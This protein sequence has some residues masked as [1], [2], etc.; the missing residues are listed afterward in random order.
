MDIWRISDHVDHELKTIYHCAVVL[1]S[2]AVVEGKDIWGFGSDETSFGH[3]SGVLC[4][5]F[6]LIHLVDAACC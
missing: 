1:G 4:S 3:R 2:E 5:Y 6:Q